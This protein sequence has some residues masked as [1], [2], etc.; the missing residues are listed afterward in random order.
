MKLSRGDIVLCKVPMPS[1][2]LK[3][4]KLR[5][6]LIVSKDLN[7]KRLND[8]MIAICTSNISRSQEPTQYLIEGNEIIQA[9][10]RISSVVKCESILTISK[11][12]IVK[13]LGT[14]SVSGIHKINY[15]LKDALGL[16]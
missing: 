6:G 10:I 12:M 16:E 9:G 5:P 15:C 8:V 14:L 3:E 2:E 13:I 4:F 7:N 11:S 1:S